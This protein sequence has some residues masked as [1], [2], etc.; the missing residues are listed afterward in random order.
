MCRD[1]IFNIGRMQNTIRRPLY[2]A[3]LSRDDGAMAVRA[4]AMSVGTLIC[5]DD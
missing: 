4:I 3:D 5:Y 2:L 1:P